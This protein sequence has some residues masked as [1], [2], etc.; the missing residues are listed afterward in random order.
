M[1]GAL[2]ESSARLQKTLDAMAVQ[3]RITALQALVGQGRSLAVEQSKE[4]ADLKQRLSELNKEPG[5]PG[6]AT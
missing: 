1:N 2:N 6:T 3:A 4:L 5:Q